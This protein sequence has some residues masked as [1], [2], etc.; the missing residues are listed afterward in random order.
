MAR[1]EATHSIIGPANNPRRVDP[2]SFAS[3][4][5]TAR[6]DHTARVHSTVSGTTSAARLLATTVIQRFWEN[7]AASQGWLIVQ[8]DVLTL[9]WIS[10][11]PAGWG[12]EPGRCRAF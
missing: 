11:T 6:L 9:T 10:Q 5:R 1:H 12:G 4:R 2:M 3:Q 7:Y 8:D